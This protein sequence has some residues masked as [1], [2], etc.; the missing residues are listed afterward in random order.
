LT[1]RPG[2]KRKAPVTLPKVS[3]LSDPSDRVK[4]SNLSLALQSDPLGLTTGEYRAR[5]KW[6]V[7]DATPERY[8][9]AKRKHRQLVTEEARTPQGA[10][11]GDR[12]KRFLTILESRG[13]LDIADKQAAERLQLFYVMSYGGSP[14]QF[15]Y[16]HRIP[17]GM[18]ELEPQEAQAEAQHYLAKV[19]ARIPRWALPVVDLIERDAFE[20]VDLFELK[21]YYC[22]Q[23]GNKRA[24]DKLNDLL[25]FVCKSLADIFEIDHSWNDR[26]RRVAQE[27]MDMQGRGLW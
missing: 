3:A 16:E 5:Q 7:G 6:G 23:L 24:K 22:P 21:D 2:R 20:D 18:R 27:I 19:R 17:G 4:V 1:R 9:H 10:R 14:A 12:R 15:N 8:Q 13:T 25:Q 26:T 11:T